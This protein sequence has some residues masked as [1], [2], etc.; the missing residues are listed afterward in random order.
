MKQQENRLGA[1]PRDAEE[2][3]EHEFF[4]EVNWDRLLK[5]EIK[6]PFVPQL[7]SPTDVDYFSKDFT[8]MNA[9]HE[10]RGSVVSIALSQWS[11]FTYAIP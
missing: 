11:G 1:G 3:K 9:E 7:K 6:P 5:R 4:K 10:S 8:D 2:I